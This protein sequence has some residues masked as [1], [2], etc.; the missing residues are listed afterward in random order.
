MGFISAAPGFRHFINTFPTDPEKIRGRRDITALEAVSVDE[1]FPCNSAIEALQVIAHHHGHDL[2]LTYLPIGDSS[3]PMRR[4]T[5]RHYFDEV[6]RAANL[7]RSLGLQ[8]DESVVFLLP[9]VPEM[10]FG[11]WG[12]QAVGIAAPVNPF[13][14][15]DQI[16][17][18]AQEANARIIV[19]LGSGEPGGAACLE[20][21]RQVRDTVLGVTHVVTV[22]A[23]RPGGSGDTICWRQA[24]ERLPDHDILG[25][26]Q[27]Q[28]GDTAAYFHTGGTTGT[29]KLARHT[30]RGQV[31]NVCQMAM[32]GP[33]A[34]RDMVGKPVT[35]CGLPL[36]HVN[37]VF[38]S[39]LSSLMGA[40]ELV[41]AG[42]HGFREKELIAHFWDIVQ[43]FQITFFAGVPTV[44]SALIQQLPPTLDSA[45]LS[46]CAC[47][48]APMPVSLLNEFRERTGA[49]ILE[50]YGMTETTTCATAHY[51]YGKRRVGSIGM[52]IPY[53]QV[54]T[55]IVDAEGHI[56]RDCDVDEI[57]VLLLKG[58]NVIPDY[59]Q[60]FANRGAWPEPGWLNSGDMARIDADGF[61]WLTGRAK[62]LI[63]RSGHN[64]DPQITEN[65]LSAHPA[66]AQVAAVGLP[67]AYA[68]EL[69]VAYVTLRP[70]ARATEQELQAF[71]RQHAAE[72][73]AAPVAV[74]IRDTLPVTQVGKLFKPPLRRDA[75]GRAYQA[76]VEA[77]RPGQRI[78]VAVEDDP[79]HGLKVV[80]RTGG[81]IQALQAALAPTL[82]RF[83]YRWE[84]DDSGASS[85]EVS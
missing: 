70:G 35:L 22:G 1:R 41:L 52:R 45:S 84:V 39:A 49:N 15:P 29:P 33:A 63:I 24:Q 68:G 51:F 13:L 66:V 57:G 85:R 77:A 10:L 55:A 4:W 50:G 72:R 16:A 8:A 38:V 81:E 54:R 26:R 44:Y 56:V 20:K 64:I 5:Y 7:F 21:A 36:F 32:T 47:G 23:N 34:G 28:G 12:A 62:D 31:V 14:E 67:D 46:H 69:P 76:A 25:L 2:A 48:A 60:E 42:S 27:I 3:R 82:D 78:E 75:I 65:A 30:H 37:A 43:Q 53:Q 73:A 83:A 74:F 17:A 59:K 71:A 6:N 79:L 18:I 40:G 61:V 11:I 58:P 9:N 19:A 80:L